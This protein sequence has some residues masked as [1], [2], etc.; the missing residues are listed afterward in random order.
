[1]NFELVYSLEDFHHEADVHD[2]EDVH[3]EYGLELVD[4][5]SNFPW[6]QLVLDA[7]LKT[8]HSHCPK[9]HCNYC[10]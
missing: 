8:S 3:H 9:T 10:P 7:G 6:Q 4:H 1:M 2:L 5:F